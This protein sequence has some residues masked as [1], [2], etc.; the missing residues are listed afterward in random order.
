[1]RKAK[2][3]IEKKIL[4]TAIISLAVVFLVQ[5]IASFSLFSSV[6]FWQKYSVYTIYLA[7]TVVATMI[8]LWHLSAYKE[9][10]THMAG[11]MTGMT[12][13]MMSGFAIG[14]IVGATNGMFIGSLVGVLLGMT[15]GA[16]AGKCCGIMGVME[17]MMAGLMA[18]TMGP[19]ISVMMLNDNLV[20]FMPLLVGSSLLIMGGLT[21]MMHKEEMLKKL[22]VKYASIEYLSFV[23]ICFLLTLG[24][25]FLM[26]FGPKSYLFG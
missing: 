12:A 20:Y 5:Y 24:I 14:A 23:T 10:V 25:S 18:G 8:T 4:Q 11:M 7:L 16:Y 15:I 6:P 1:M 26:V 17:G 22:P 3:L 19:M 9:T 13:G 21:Y 2:Y